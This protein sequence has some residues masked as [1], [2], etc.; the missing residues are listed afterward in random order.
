MVTHFTPSML[1]QQRAGAKLEA[2]RQHKKVKVPAA[3]VSKPA[4]DES[5]TEARCAKGR[6]RTV[7][8]IN[9]ISLPAA[10]S[11]SGLPSN[12]LST[13]ATIFSTSA[14]EGDSPT[15]TPLTSSPILRPISFSMFSIS[16]AFATASCR[17][18]SYSPIASHTG[19]QRSSPASAHPSSAK[20][21]SVTALFKLIFHSSTT[22]IV[23]LAPSPT[24][25]PS[26]SALEL[27]RSL[28]FSSSCFNASSMLPTLPLFSTS[29]SYST[30][31]SSMLSALFT[32]SSSP[33]SSAKYALLS[34]LPPSPRRE[35]D[36]SELLEAS[37]ISTLCVV[38]R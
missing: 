31:V 33:S 36:S 30:S 17:N 22:F 11:C 34:S 18:A 13:L 25:F 4:S 15:S 1:I 38:Q 2:C 19:L 8:A 16:F 7:P 6:G 12:A 23:F 14:R 35:G 21:W 24:L 32:A 27:A 3:V 5:E 26:H 10:S 37:A 9:F 29:F 28:S 20:S